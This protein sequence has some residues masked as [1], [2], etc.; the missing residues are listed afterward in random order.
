MANKSVRAK[1]G[2][3]KGDSLSVM[4]E[5]YAA[6]RDKENPEV[7]Q[8]GLASKAADR[9][10]DEIKKH[11]MFE[12]FNRFDVSYPNIRVY[13]RLTKVDG[14]EVTMLQNIYISPKFQRQGVTST[15][16]G[17][18]K[19]EFKR[20]VY[21]QQVENEGWKKSLESSPNWRKVGERDFISTN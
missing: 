16:V 9:V 21:I 1:A 5:K 12:R 2:I 11:P 19:K 7:Q 4:R 8:A 18:L 15:L 3:K 13:G 10:I 17:K 20:P 14:Q 6:Y